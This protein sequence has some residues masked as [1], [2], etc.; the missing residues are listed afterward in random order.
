MEAT[1]TQDRKNVV[2]VGGG[3]AG[4]GAAYHLVKTNRYNVTLLE[5]GKA[6]G[7]LVA[8]FQS[9]D[10]KPSEIGIHGAWR[11]YRNL[12]HF[13]ETEL[14]LKDV[15]TDWTES[16]SFSPRGKETSAPIFA[17]QPRLPS[18][19]GTLAYTK[20]HRLPLKDRLS[21]LP[22]L[23]TLADFDPRSKEDWKRY[24]KMSARELFRRAGVTPAL[25][26]LIE[27]MLLVGTFCPGEQTSAAACLAFLYFFI[28]SHQDSFDVRWPR[29][30][31]GELI[32]GP[33]SDQIRE[34]GGSILTEKRVTDYAMDPNSNKITRVVCGGENFDADV[35]IS[36]VGIN[37]MQGILKTSKTLA[38]Y[39]E[40]RAVN[41]L[42]AIDVMAV[43]LYLDRKIQLDRP[44]NAVFGFDDTTGWTIFDLNALH[45][46]Y[47]SESNSV[48]ECDFYGAQQFLPMQ[49]DEIV[50]KVKGYL[51][52]INPGF[53]D[54]V[55]RDAT[56]LRVPKGVTHFSPGSHQHM[57]SGTTSIS[58]FLC[59]GDWIWT[60]H[61]SF[62]QE[63]ALVSGLE[64]SNRAIDIL[65]GQNSPH[66]HANILPVPQDEAHITSIRKIAKELRN[67]KD[68]V[69]PDL[70]WM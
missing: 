22:L 3:W 52:R 54:A 13:V 30:T 4:L 1:E 65:E 18:P 64:A 45:D 31:S 19:F 43:R 51:G 60:S 55:V 10:G 17:D 28:L 48:I 41:K 50:T 26:E 36:C 68:S 42:Y 47:R 29:G 49:D 57:L 67:V 58:N 11:P 61:G 15:F 8:G 40:F 6:I 63:R 5:A 39:P 27:S 14:G 9:Q 33:L 7:G 70:C 44:S 37:G 20:F 32:F 24:D 25:Y 59:A 16:D 23:L 38:R 66:L 21:A 53:Q 62:S 46:R 56:V 35:V 2:V 34:L 12:F 69:A